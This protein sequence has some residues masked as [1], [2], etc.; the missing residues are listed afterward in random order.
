MPEEGP[1]TCAKC[2]M[3]I[4]DPRLPKCKICG[5]A[6]RIAPAMA[7]PQ[8]TI[9][10]GKS[11]FRASNRMRVFRFQSRWSSR[12]RI[13]FN[14]IITV[15]LGLCIRLS[16]QEGALFVSADWLMDIWLFLVLPM[17]LFKTATAHFPFWSMDDI[18]FGRG[19]GRG[20]RQEAAAALL[21]WFWQ[22]AIMMVILEAALPK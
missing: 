2:G 12:K 1:E 21:S 4:L 11:T 18:F 19:S 13:V 15:A 6:R 8:P 10:R 5:A 17:V 16:D 20:F 7:R 9:R 14:S 3:V 22:F